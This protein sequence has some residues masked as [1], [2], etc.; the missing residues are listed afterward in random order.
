[1][2]LR[3]LYALIAGLLITIAWLGLRVNAQNKA[4]AKAAVP[5]GA[6]AAAQSTGVDSR[7]LQ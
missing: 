7:L 1:M 4:A 2:K 3:A 6:L 5:E